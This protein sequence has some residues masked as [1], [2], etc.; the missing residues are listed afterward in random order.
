M[1]NAN[2]KQGDAVKLMTIHKSKGLEF[3]VI[4]MVGVS[5]GILP[6]NMALNADNIEEERRL[7]YVGITRAEDE[8]YVSSLS[9]YQGKVVAVSTFITEAELEQ[10]AE[11]I[12]NTEEVR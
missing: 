8:L 9:T 2:T 12:E 10:Y 11:D 7:A 3:P 4:F 1:L 5:E 6:H